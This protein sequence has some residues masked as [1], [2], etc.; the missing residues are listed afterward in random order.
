MFLKSGGYQAE[1][2]KQQ[3]EKIWTVVK[4]V[5]GVLNAATILAIGVASV[6]FEFLTPQ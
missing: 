3:R 2:R 6:Y 1:K 5:V 4:I